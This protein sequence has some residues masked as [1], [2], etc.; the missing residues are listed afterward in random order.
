MMEVDFEHL[1]QP[2]KVAAIAHDHWY[3]PGQ[4]PEPSAHQQV[5][6]ASRLAGDEQ[7]DSHLSLRVAQPHAS[8][9]PV[10]ERHQLRMDAVRLGTGALREDPHEEPVPALDVLL[11]G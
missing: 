5:D 6:C 11:Q 7:P 3:Q 2:G 8:A 1:A 10:P 9:E 4:L